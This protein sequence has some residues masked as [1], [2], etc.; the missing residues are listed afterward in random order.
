M[1]EEVWISNFMQQSWR[2]SD[3]SVKTLFDTHNCGRVFVNK[4]ANKEWV[5]K[6]VADKFRNVG[7]MTANEIID[8]V[9]RSYI[10]GITP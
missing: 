3:F 8:D 5:S 6:I 9:R 10:I 7:R 4:N 2:K 1:Q